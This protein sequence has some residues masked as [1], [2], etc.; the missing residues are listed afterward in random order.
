MKFLSKKLNDFARN[1]TLIRRSNGIKRQSTGHPISPDEMT[2][3]QK[4]AKD[5]WNTEDVAITKPEFLTPKKN[6]WRR[7]TIRH[8]KTL[9]RRLSSINNGYF[10]I[11]TDGLN[12]NDSTSPLRKSASVASPLTSQ[13][14][15]VLLLNWCQNILKPYVDLEISEPVKDFSKSWQNGVAFLSLIHSI[16]N[17]IVPEIDIL[18]QEKI[19]NGNNLVNILPT[20]KRTASLSNP[21]SN[22]TF[23]LYTAEPKDWYNNLERAFNLAEKYF[24]IISLLEPNDIVSVKNP[25]ERI[26]MTYISE[27]YWYIN[28]EKK[29][30]KEGRLSS[31]SERSENENYS[32]DLEVLPKNRKRGNLDSN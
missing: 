4:L 6:S 17:D 15:K 16:R 9:N 8:S 22:S 19:E 27:F 18:V 12:N 13:N 11:K 21:S 25:D 23:K 10:N 26:I 2:N 14:P 32:D 30:A 5:S 3:E 28:K 1:S 29:L 7:S 31:P 24:K 20:P